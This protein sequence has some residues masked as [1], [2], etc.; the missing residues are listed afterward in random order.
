MTDALHRNAQNEM[1]EPPT[2]DRHGWCCGKRRL[3]TISYPIGSFCN[4]RYDYKDRGP[5]MYCYAGRLSVEEV[6][7]FSR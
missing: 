1:A 3:I 6:T 2:A 7:I 4:V 5:M